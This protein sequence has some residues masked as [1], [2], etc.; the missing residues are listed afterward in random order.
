M[1]EPG[2]AVSTRTQLL[3]LFQGE[4]LISKP[5]RSNAAGGW[6]C[7]YLSPCPEVGTAEETI[8]W[9]FLLCFSPSPPPGSHQAGII[10]NSPCLIVLPGHLSEEMSSLFPAL[11]CRQGH[12]ASAGCL[13][14][15][16]PNPEI[17]VFPKVIICWDANWAR[18]QSELKGHSSTGSGAVGILWL[19]PKGS[20]GNHREVTGAWE[21]VCKEIKLK[22]CRKTAVGLHISNSEWYPV[23]L[24]SCLACEC[25]LTEC[26]ILFSLK[27]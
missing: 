11:R 26:R 17:Q 16:L 8:R 1:G 23:G 7:A 2:G 22:M 21:P 18:P 5:N 13:R 19:C 24:K 20:G 12:G 15:W 4:H 10:C 14:S 25:W 27:Y 6:S 9:C 3:R